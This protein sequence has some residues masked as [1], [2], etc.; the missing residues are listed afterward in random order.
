M[1]ARERDD[2]GGMPGFEIEDIPARAVAWF[3]VAFTLVT[4]MLVIAVT[5]FGRGAWQLIADKEFGPLETGAPPSRP[6]LQTTPAEDFAAFR[7]RA[8]ARLN[9]AGW[10]DRER[11]IAHI[12]IE[13]A[14][15]RLAARG[16]ANAD[17]E[18]AR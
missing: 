4:V 13:D 15:R 14:M 1:S 17:E 11:G 16:K 5:L 8:L 10:I 3:G 6:E 12:P 18:R 7:E 2:T 9:G